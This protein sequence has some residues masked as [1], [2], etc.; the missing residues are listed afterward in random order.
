[1]P[2][3]LIA[4]A[5]FAL[6]AAVNLGIIGGYTLGQGAMIAIGGAIV[7]GGALVAKKV[8]NLFEIEMPK[9]DTDRS[10]QATVR[11]T[12]EAHKVVYGESLVSGPVAF[13]GTA[14]TENR[15][16]YY[17]IALAGHECQSITD[18]HFDNIVI[19][20]GDI[21]ATSTNSANVSTTGAVSGSGIFGPVGSP[22]TTIVQINKYLGTETQDA[23]IMLRDAFPSKWTADHDGKGIAYIVTKW[24]LNDDSAEIWDKYTPRDIKAL[25]KGRKIYDPR[26]DST[27]SA[28]DASLGVSDHRFTDPSTYDWS[29]NP[30]L[31]LADYLTAVDFTDAGS[32]IVGRD[33]RIESIGT[34]DFT[35]IGAVSNTVGVRFTATGLGSG[36]GNASRPSFGMGI[37]ESKIDWDA[38]ATAADAC[39]VSVNVPG[40]TE[41]RFTC[42]GVVFGTDSHRTNINKILSSMNGNLSYVNGKYVARAGIWEAGTVQ[43]TEDDL[44]APVSVKTSLERS[45]RFNTI[46]GVFLDPASNYKTTEFPE[47]QLADAVTRDSGEVLSKE[48]AL[49][50][51][52]SSYMAQ[53]IA[54]KLIQLTDQ[55]KVIIFPAN[56]TALRVAVGDRVQVT[57][58]ELDWSNKD[59]QCV[60][61]SFNE[62]GGV[63]LT[64]REDSDQSYGDPLTGAYSQ[65]TSDGTI[66]DGFRGVPSPSA[67]RG[68]SSED[69]VF[70]DWTNPGNPQDFETIHVFAS[71]T[72]N[73]ANAIKVGETDGSQFTL[74]SNSGAGDASEFATNDTRYFWVRAIRFKGT[75]DQARSN[76]EPNNSTQGIEVTITATAVDWS[77]VA[78]PQVGITLDSNDN[79]T[80]DL[81]NASSSTTGAAVTTSGI[82]TD[83]TIAEGGLT[84]NSGGA[85]RSTGKDSE[86]DADAG[87]FL[88]WN[89]SA[90]GGNGSYTF[91]VGDSSQNLQYADGTLSVTGDI[92]ATSLNL[93]SNVISGDNLPLEVYAADAPALHNADPY[94]TNRDGDYWFRNNNQADPAD[95]RAEF[96]YETD[97]SSLPT[98]RSTYFKAFDN[99]DGSEDLFSEIMQ[100]NSTKTYAITVWARQPSGDRLNYLLV[101]FQKS[102]GTR[103]NNSSTPVSDA[104]GWSIGTYHYYTIVDD[105]FASDWTKYEVVFG[106]NSTFEIPTDAAQFSVGALL[107]RD[108]P[109]GT[110]TTVE[111]AQMLV[112]EFDNQVATA[113]ITDLGGTT[114]T[115]DKLYQHTGG[116]TPALGNPNTGFYLDSGGNFSLKD[117]LQFNASNDTLTVDGTIEAQNFAVLSSSPDD[118]TNVIASDV[119]GGS[120]SADAFDNS[121][122]SAI[123]LR[124]LQ[125]SGAQADTNVPEV[126]ETAS[127]T[128]IG[129]PSAESGPF[130]V[131]I[132]GAQTHSGNDI[133]IAGSINFAWSTTSNFTNPSF[134]LQVER[135]D[136]SAFTTN[137]VGVGSP[138]VVNATKA[139][140]YT[141]YIYTAEGAVS[142]STNPTNGDYYW[143]LKIA[144]S[145]GVSVGPGSLLADNTA[146]FSIFESGGTTGSTTNT[147]SVGGLNIGGDT[148]I[149]G[150]L[151]VTGTTTTL[152]SATLQ[153]ADNNIVLNYLD[154]ADSSATADGS[155]ITVQDAVSSG[156]N[157]SITWL[158]GSDVWRPSH[159][160]SVNGYVRAAVGA[161]GKGFYLDTGSSFDGSNAL[162]APGIVW[163]ES[164]GTQIA[165]IRGRVQDDGT[166]TL[167]LGVGWLTERLFVTSTG[168]GIT[169]GLELNNTNLTGVNALTFEDPGP[170][171]GI[172]WAGGNWAVYESPDDLSTNT[173]GNLQFVRGGSRK[174][175]FNNGI[176]TFRN[177]GSTAQSILQI[178]SDQDNAQ[179]ELSAD[180]SNQA[181]FAYDADPRIVWS[182]KNT[183]RIYQY[184]DDSA[185]RMTFS[186]SA[187]DADPAG[188][189]FDTS[190]NVFTTGAIEAGDL[191]GGG[192]VY[193]KGRDSSVTGNRAILGLAAQDPG[194]FFGNGLKP[195]T[196][197]FGFLESTTESGSVPVSAM[198][199]GRNQL[200]LVRDAGDSGGRTDGTDVTSDVDYK[201]DF[202]MSSD[203]V[204]LY[205]ADVTTSGVLDAGS[206]ELDGT[207][208]AT[209]TEKNINLS[210]FSSSN[211]YPVVL[212]NAPNQ[213]QTHEFIISQNSQ[214][215]ADPYNNNMIVGWARGQG[216]SDMTT[217][218]N[219]HYNCYQDN[220]RTILGMYRGTASSNV[221]IFYLRG[222]ENYF[223]KTASAVTAYTSGY[224]SGTSSADLTVAMIKDATG[225]DIG[226]QSDASQR[227]AVL[228]DLIDE[229]QGHYQSLRTFL[230]QADITN[231]LNAGSIAT[232]GTLTALNDITGPRLRL[233]DTTDASLSSTAHAFQIG[234]SNGGN[235]IMDTNELNARNNG[236]IAAMNINADGGDVQFANNGG[237]TNLKISGNT[238][239]DNDRNFTGQSVTLTE[240]S[241][242]ADTSVTQN[243]IDF[244]LSGSDALTNDRTNIALR[245]D[246]DSTATGGD[247]SNEHRVYGIYT[248]VDVT[249]DSDIVRASLNQ[250]RVSPFGG[251]TIS[252]AESLW[253]YTDIRHDAGTVS[254]AVG[255]I[256]YCYNLTTGSG[257][258]T[259]LTGGYDYA[260][261]QSTSSYGSA[262]YTGTRSLARVVGSVNTSNTNLLR[263]SYG[264]VILD[265]T[266]NAQTIGDLRAYQANID[267]GTGANYTISSTYLFYGSYTGT[268][269]AT[270][271]W[272]IYIASSVDNYFAGNIRSAGVI[273]TSDGAV[274]GPSYSFDGDTNTGMYSP[275]N[276]QLGFAV[277]GSR[278]FYM[279]TTKAFFQNLSDGVEIGGN[280]ILGNSTDISMSA[281]SAGHLNIQGNGYDGAIALDGTAM[282]IY[283]NSSSRSLILGTDETAR[284]TIAGN[285]ESTFAQ[286]ATFSGGISLANASFTAAVNSDHITWTGGGIRRMTTQGGVSIGA[287]SSVMIHA[288]DNRAN[289][290]TFFSIADTTTAETLYLTADGIVKVVTGMQLGA[291]NQYEFLFNNNGTFTAPSNITAYS[292]ARLK[293]GVRVIPDA[294]TKLRQIRGV[295][296]TRNDQDDKQRRHMG[297]IA[298]ELEAA[299]VSEVVDN[300]GDYKSVAYGN[301]VALCIESIK[302]LTTKVEELEN[303]LKEK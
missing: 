12:T 72:N 102:D 232:G 83:I 175:T 48:I 191:D 14:G 223:F 16:L 62:E 26:K 40:G 202:N 260:L 269:P 275:G 96:T 28:Y 129:S 278:K 39:D 267:T 128:G 46:K 194:W 13:M 119:K 118:Q 22:A 247:T 236:G 292:D 37:V 89:P 76:I 205:S 49:N 145:S 164:D 7:A 4:V 294:L 117:K 290:G 88:G 54:N 163:R 206:Y 186:T 126:N 178:H 109:T 43:L 60:G 174:V 226:S 5:Q 130:Y 107:C 268:N 264:Q 114:I 6:T 75:S 201:L 82:E 71:S 213:T 110:Q 137:L 182:S 273:R 230:P 159:P 52:N 277:D 243:Y 87:F 74:E 157:A 98:G 242:V 254:N 287:D 300:S 121:V 124:I 301:L 281:S 3:V 299:G 151:T 58:D 34:T 53:R 32:F 132:S 104:S 239:L 293:D 135:A 95:G 155:G 138:V 11:G 263:G 203:T 144:P 86:S 279:S 139:L 244:N 91:G 65:I 25:V 106:P 238:F 10:R 27:S 188:F 241:T 302:E 44:T 217:A 192:A 257:Q 1:M 215:G 176:Y 253:N 218:H 233:T 246:I 67:L 24:N 259:Q 222:G 143:R 23:D 35:A 197:N 111:I 59:F 33:Y 272:G 115:R 41:K 92:T 97:G 220:E 187:S 63:N 166:N 270:N 69:K 280:V 80:T 81:T 160:W 123:D 193:F 150:N 101:D 204:N 229:E 255:N 90:N 79:I 9:V 136:N 251:G 185:S 249:G 196:V 120:V 38:I 208:V 303:K 200:I 288:G 78:D 31:C 108:G 70:L 199:L 15:D 221:I 50:M 190:G 274:S 17:C 262:T 45:D 227:L 77:N 173:A 84:L 146:A 237:T 240:S 36:T 30:A 8:M 276:H 248:T 184:W 295:T 141:V 170:G 100:I 55:Q 177:A 133:Q 158:A 165:G 172:S 161:G 235:L 265:N 296:Y 153:V 103:I 68:I 297:V 66:E 231:S 131:T 20:S 122:W 2:Q 271:I 47:V 112:E 207:A 42:N 29:D 169:G 225:A 210:A 252:N 57:L 212:S 286:L 285:G 219:F 250:V 289:W 181:A 61:W 152:D 234:P 189:K 127:L 168:V 19:P 180:I 291:G 283:H 228:V 195:R 140:A 156:N 149:S 64:L 21:A 113:G 198:I 18:I 284:V 224:N 154:G 125:A 261:A 245:I 73:F 105:P 258:A 282:H 216:W 256:S 179:L 183:V 266:S 148:T 93:G 167:A 51:T 99:D 116:T 171:E 214:S 162:N 298:Q 94:F 211:F 147:G 85:I 209:F 142:F 56:M 134:T